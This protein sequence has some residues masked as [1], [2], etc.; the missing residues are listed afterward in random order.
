MCNKH[1]LSSI[2]ANVSHNNILTMCSDLLWAQSADRPP[3]GFIVVMLVDMAL[4]QPDS[5]CGCGDR[6]T[7]DFLEITVIHSF[8]ARLQLDCSLSEALT[9]GKS[10]QDTRLIIVCLTREISG[11]NH[12]CLFLSSRGNHKSF[13]GM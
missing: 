2:S 4:K 7:L 11:F 1:H 12:L 9:A 5:S 8:I 6:K 3:I 13:S 10:F